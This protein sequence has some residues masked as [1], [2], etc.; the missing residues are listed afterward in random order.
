[1]RVKALVALV[2]LGALAL[3]LWPKPQPSIRPEDVVIK[4][5]LL[6]PGRAENPAPGHEDHWALEITLDSHTDRPL[7]VSDRD[8]FFW[9]TPYVEG[10]SAVSWDFK[11]G[12]TNGSS[13]Y[14]VGGEGFAIGADG[15]HAIL[16]A[17]ALGAHG[18][19]ITADEAF[20]IMG[21]GYY[22]ESLPA[23]IRYYLPAAESAS[24]G[25]RGY[26]VYSHYERRWGRDLSWAKA[27]PVDADSIR[28]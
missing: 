9:V 23:E 7:Y 10:M 12:L 15:R 4:A 28:P 2:V 17:E 16:A 24:A 5:V 27:F 6:P 11:Q 1:M 20:Q 19:S 8:W 13:G 21:F 22:G 25:R 26:V 3:L 14:T 18:I